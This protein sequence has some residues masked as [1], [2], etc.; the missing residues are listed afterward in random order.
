M[1]LLAILGFTIG[2]NMI[3]F[4][5][6]YLLMGLPYGLTGNLNYA[7]IAESVDYAEWKSG[8][9]TEGI[10]AS[11]QTFMNKIM[12]T[13]QNALIPLMLLIFNFTEPS[14]SNITPVQSSLTKTGLMLIAS[15]IPMIAWILNLLI[16]TKY[17]LHGDY[18]KNMYIE[19]NQ[20]RKAAKENPSQSII[21]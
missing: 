5:A 20:Q 15:I 8:R 16:I 6:M 9:R 3:L 19:L 10:S 17:P 13:L 18:R 12:T 21:I 4:V 2:P 11:M 14:D 1:A 7:M